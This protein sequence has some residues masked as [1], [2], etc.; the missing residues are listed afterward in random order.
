MYRYIAGTLVY[1]QFE[2]LCTSQSRKGQKVPQV[3]I[4]KIFVYICLSKPYTGKVCSVRFFYYKSLQCALFYYKA[5]SVRRVYITFIVFLLLLPDLII[6]ACITILG[7]VHRPCKQYTNIIENGLCHA[8]PFFP[9][10]FLMFWA[11]LH[12]LPYQEC[13]QTM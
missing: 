3:R 6:F 4:L 5:C 2:E 11:H 10:L 1:F 7:N 8:T 13:A 9:D 12:E